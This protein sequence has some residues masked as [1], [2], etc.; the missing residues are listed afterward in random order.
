MG[1]ASGYL[2]VL[3]LALYINSDQVV[4]LYRLPLAL[5]LACPLLLF[6]IGRMW[7]LAYRGK[8]H[9]DPIVAAVRDPASYLIG[10]L[11][12]LVMYLAL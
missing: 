11:V 2:S 9:D 3:V 10:L 8:I 4:A 12:A 7:L 6:W 1:S 5:W